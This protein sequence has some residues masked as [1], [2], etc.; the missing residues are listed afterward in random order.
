MKILKNFGEECKEMIDLKLVHITL[1]NMRNMIVRKY[2]NLLR[3][4]AL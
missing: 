2:E 1:R 3:C 4:T